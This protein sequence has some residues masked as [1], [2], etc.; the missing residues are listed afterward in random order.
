MTNTNNRI[1]ALLHAVHHQLGQLP[2]GQ[3]LRSPLLVGRYSPSLYRIHRDTLVPHSRVQ[4]PG[5]VPRN[6]LKFFYFLVSYRNTFNHAHSLIIDYEK[7]NT[8]H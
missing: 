7:L 6:I 4:P 3:A 5:P 1:R 2:Y 8:K